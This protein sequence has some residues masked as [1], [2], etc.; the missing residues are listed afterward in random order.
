M[1][2][3]SLTSGPLV[4]RNRCRCAGCP[5]PRTPFPLCRSPA[6]VPHPTHSSHGFRVLRVTPWH[7][8]TGCSVGGG[9][10]QVHGGVAVQ[11]THTLPGPCPPDAVQDEALVGVWDDHPLVPLTAQA[12]KHNTSNFSQ[13][14]GNAGTTC[15][16]TE[17]ACGGPAPGGHPLVPLT[18][19]IMGKTQQTRFGLAAWEHNNNTRE[20]RKHMR[21][22]GPGRARRRLAMRALPPHVCAG[23]PAP[24]TSALRAGVR[25]VPELNR[26]GAV[27][28]MYLVLCYK[29]AHSRVRQVQLAHLVVHLQAGLLDHHLGVDGLAGLRGCGGTNPHFEK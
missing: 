19:C 29:C 24:G 1:Q 12:T 3:T 10:G 2:S 15:K 11:L 21:G 9:L 6:P 25:L 27:C 5:A 26:Y 7:M 18:A 28:V 22:D 20:H 14:H 23:G 16:G 13:Q 4:C 17:T 8:P